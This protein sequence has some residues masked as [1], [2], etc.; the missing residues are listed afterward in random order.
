[1]WLV[2]L[3]K[4]HKLGRTYGRICYWSLVWTGPTQELKLVDWG[5]RTRRPPD[6]IPPELENDAPDVRTV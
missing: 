6:S 4:L 2:L 3:P 5:R 1:M